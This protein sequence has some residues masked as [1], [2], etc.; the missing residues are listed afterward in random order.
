MCMPSSC[1]PSESPSFRG[2]SAAVCVPA[3]ASASSAFASVS[4]CCASRTAASTVGCSVSTASSAAGSASRS[5][6]HCGC[7]M[8]SLA[9]WSAAPAWHHPRVSPRQQHRT[10]WRMW[11]YLQHCLRAPRHQVH[12]PPS[13]PLQASPA[14]HLPRLAHLPVLKARRDVSPRA[15]PVQAG[16]PLIPAAAP[17]V[18]CAFLP[19]FLLPMVA[20]SAAC[21][22]WSPNQ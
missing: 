9:C 6:S 16:V 4:A 7:S 8:A 13:P 17:C 10:G 1:P 22:R 12:S 15:S 5:A 19:F 20:P 14:P 2:D 18:P 11:R 21:H 3:A